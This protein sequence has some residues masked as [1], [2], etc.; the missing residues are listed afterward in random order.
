[1]VMKVFTD[2]K[3]LYH[4]SVVLVFTNSLNLSLVTLVDW[5]HQILRSVYGPSS[6]FQRFCGLGR[7][8][9]IPGDDNFASGVTIIHKGSEI[10]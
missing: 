7:G 4:L 9:N 10:D 5:S 3:L 6:N 8:M 2:G 1:M